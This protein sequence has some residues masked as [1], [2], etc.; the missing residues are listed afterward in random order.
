MNCADISRKMDPIFSQNH[1]A[2]IIFE[3]YDFKEYLDEYNNIY[4]IEK[5]ISKK[6]SKKATK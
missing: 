1:N 3:D 4:A 5:N 2:Y 6:S